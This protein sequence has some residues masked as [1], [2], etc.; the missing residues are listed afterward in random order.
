MS[1]RL[2]LRQLRAYQAIMITGSVSGAAERLNMSQPAISRQLAALEEAL[3]FRLFNRRSGGPMQATRAGVQFYKAMESTLAR[4]DDLP[5]IAREI[6]RR[7]REWVRIAATPP[8]INSRLLADTLRLF[9]TENENVR[10]VLEARHRLDIEEWVVSRQVDLGLALLPVENP[11]IASVP[12][13]TQNAVAVVHEDH[14]LAA[15]NVVSPADLEGERLILPSRQPLRTFIDPALESSDVDLNIFI[16]TSALTCCKYAAEGF[17][18]A[19]CDPFSPTAFTGA[20]LKTLNWTPEVPLTYGAIFTI[21]NRHSETV[22]NFLRYIK[23]A[24]LLQNES[25]TL[26]V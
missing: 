4:L 6:A 12:L 3:G 19:I 11:M 15:R 22:D 16:E 26:A 20:R 9:S 17:G 2:R 7:S 1:E 18:V 13:V 25:K 21:E 10:L 5:M 23:K 24:L 14:R 8:L